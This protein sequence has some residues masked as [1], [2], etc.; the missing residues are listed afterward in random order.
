MF[1][2]LLSVA[3]LIALG[4]GAGFYWGHVFSD[5]G[6][7][8]S[9]SAFSLRAPSAYPYVSPLLLC[10]PSGG[11]SSKRD[12]DF[13]H[14]LEEDIDDIA[15]SNTKASVYYRDLLTGVWFGINENEQYAPS[16]MLKVPL[17]I[18]YLKVSESNPDLLTLNVNFTADVDLDAPQHFQPA[19]RP[20]PGTSYTVT[21]L[22]HYMLKDSDNNAANFLDEMLQVDTK[23]EVYTDLGLSFPKGVA[24]DADFMSVLDYARFFRVLYNAT[25]LSTQESDKLMSWLTEARFPFGLSGGIPDSVEIAQ[26]FGENTVDEDG[27]PYYELHDC[28]V[29]Y[30]PEHPYLLCVMTKSSEPFETLST[31]IQ[32]ISKTV[33]TEVDRR[34]EP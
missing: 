11:G 24:E 34:Y 33:Y 19:E 29:V 23:Q 16:S 25:Y 8:T 10:S 2:K 7:L 30:Y 9:D 15:T 22:I 28:G 27:V 17:A 20:E 14:F 26:K 1:K 3:I 13:Q 31:L 32:S 4:V 5:S 21:D 6:S 18:A 12:E